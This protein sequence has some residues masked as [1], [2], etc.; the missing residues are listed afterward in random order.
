MSKLT[1]QESNLAKFIRFGIY[2][3]ALVPLLV[4][5]D[6]ISPFHFG[7]VVIFRSL[8]EILGAA[9]LILVLKEKT[10]LPRRDKIFW[11]FLFFTSAFTLTTVTSVLKYPSFWGTLERMGGLWTFWHYFLFYIILTSVL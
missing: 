4:F 5:R 2:L 11:A 7:K 8:V 6:L 10:Y 1:N 9:Y 3:T